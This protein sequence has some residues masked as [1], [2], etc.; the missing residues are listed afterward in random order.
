MCGRHTRCT[1]YCAGSHVAQGRGCCADG[2]V[3]EGKRSVNTRRNIDIRACD[4]IR[5][6][7]AWYIQYQP[8]GRQRLVATV[9]RKARQQVVNT[10]LKQG[11]QAFEVQNTEFYPPGTRKPWAREEDRQYTN[12]LSR[13]FTARLHDS[14][15]LHK[16]SGRSTASPKPRS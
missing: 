1:P 12:V 16:T 2:S 3:P 10:R 14:G 7:Q 5:Q 8:P 11:N 15:P 6:L 13:P 4:H 9:V